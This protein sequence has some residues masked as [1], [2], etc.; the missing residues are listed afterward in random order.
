MTPPSDN[1][2]LDKAIAHLE[3]QV[4]KTGVGSVKVK[5]GEVFMFSVAKL[6]EIVINAANAG[7][8]KIV[9][10]VKTGQNVSDLMLN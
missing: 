9:I 2:D 5:D 8:K 4:E 6:A 7:E 10:F 3:T 1:K